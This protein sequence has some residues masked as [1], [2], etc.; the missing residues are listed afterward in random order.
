MTHT[1]FKHPALEREC[2]NTKQHLRMQ[3][4]QK[5]EADFSGI[6][7]VFSFVFQFPFPRASYYQIFCLSLLSIKG[8]VSALLRAS[9]WVNT[10]TRKSWSTS[11][12]QVAWLLEAQLP[13]DVRLMLPKAPLR[14]GELA[15]T[16]HN[17]TQMVQRSIS[18]KII[19]YTFL[20][21]KPPPSL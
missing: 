6:F 19:L 2:K 11:A 1:I 16:K 21:P 10:V 20:I 4:V 5:S 17:K 12:T 15:Y 14:Q 13:E 18:S 9:H 8:K 7:V 3:K